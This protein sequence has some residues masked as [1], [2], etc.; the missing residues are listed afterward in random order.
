[1]KI[2]TDIEGFLGKKVYR[3]K[4]LIKLKERFNSKKITFVSIEFTKEN[5]ANCE[6]LFLRKDSLLDYIITD[7]DKAEALLE[8]GQKQELLER[9]VKILE[10]EKTLLSSF[11]E[12]EIAELKNFS[13]ITAKPIVLSEGGDSEDTLERIIDEC[14]YISFFAAGEKE[15]RAWL[16]KKGSTIVDAAGKIHT[17]LAKG[18]IRA[19]V[20]NVDGLDEYK[21]PHDARARGIMKV[22]DRQYIINNGDVIDIK[23]KV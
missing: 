3:D 18:F 13:F 5:I 2:F 20:Y 12:E 15:A 11:K 21:N 22:V 1:M 4:R 6:G 8:K 16:I 7:L 14:G 23:F 9:V 17:D 19:E 10:E